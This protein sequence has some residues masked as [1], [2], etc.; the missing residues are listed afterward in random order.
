MSGESDKDHIDGKRVKHEHNHEKLKSFGA[1]CKNSVV[2]CFKIKCMKFFKEQLDD[3][4]VRAYN[5]FK[6]TGNIT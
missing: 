1:S 2:D 5:T 4:S 6:N 3:K